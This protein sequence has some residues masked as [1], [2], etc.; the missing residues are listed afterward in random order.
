MNKIGVIRNTDELVD[1]NKENIEE[2]VE[3]ILDDF[4]IFEFIELKNKNDEKKI[5]EEFLEIIHNEISKKTGNKN[6]VLSSY[7]LVETKKF[8]YIGYYVDIAEMVMDKNEDEIKEFKETYDKK[9]FNMFGSQIIDRNVISDLY[10]AKYDLEYE[11]KDKNVKTIKKFSNFTQYQLMNK[12]ISKYKKTGYI[13][14]ENGDIKEYQY[15]QKPIENIILTDKDYEKHYRIHDYEV[16]TKVMRIIVDIRKEN[17]KINLKASYLTGKTVYGSIKVGFYEKAFERE[18]SN[19]VNV[20]K[21]CF[22]KII[23]IRGYDTKITEN[24]N[25]VQN[26]E[27]INFENLVDLEHVSGRKLHFDD[28]ILNNDI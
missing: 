24:F 1:F 8:I 19:Y 13:I 7:P 15:I 25:T 17:K 9:N 28:V 22:E 20:S 3:D 5:E 6:I 11:V 21:E 26:D 4:T 14:H 16:F 27:Y 2:Q 23:E 10:I 18:D 12:L